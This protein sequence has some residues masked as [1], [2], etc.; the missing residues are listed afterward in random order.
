MIFSRGREGRDLVAAAF[1]PHAREDPRRGA[2]CEKCLRRS[3]LLSAAAM[4][5]HVD[6][7]DG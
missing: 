2:G 6:L 1:A 4:I 7:D 5:L 3:D